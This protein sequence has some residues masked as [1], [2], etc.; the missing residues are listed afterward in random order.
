MNKPRSTCFAGKVAFDPKRCELP[1]AT[2]AEPQLNRRSSRGNPALLRS[3]LDFRWSRFRISVNG[4]DGLPLQ[5]GLVN[6]PSS[7]LDLHTLTRAHHRQIRIQMA[8]H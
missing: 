4:S 7:S 2:L 3:C 1:D 5:G 8:P 6:R